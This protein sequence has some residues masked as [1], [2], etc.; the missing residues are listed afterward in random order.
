VTGVVTTTELSQSS[1]WLATTEPTLPTLCFTVFS[2]VYL[3]AVSW[4]IPLTIPQSSDSHLNAASFDPAWTTL[5]PS[6]VRPLPHSQTMT[7]GSIY[8][9][10]INNPSLDTNRYW[11]FVIGTGTAVACQKNSATDRVANFCHRNNTICYYIVA[12]LS[13]VPCITIITI[14]LSFSITLCFVCRC[15][16]MDLVCNCFRYNLRWRWS[17]VSFGRAAWNIYSICWR[18]WTCPYFIGNTE[19][20]AVFFFVL[21]SLCLIW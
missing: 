2:A 12:G 18:T 10:S 14:Q 5:P 16:H 19:L 17:V 20:S 1:R 7:A 15:I 3:G 8:L 21:S 11:I 9:F 4:K 13:L 6:P